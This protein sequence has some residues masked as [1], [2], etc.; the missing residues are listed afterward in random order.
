MCYIAGLQSTCRSSS[1]GLG[2]PFRVAGGGGGVGWGF[3]ERV[4]VEGS[5][6]VPQGFTD[7]R[8]LGF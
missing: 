7:Q 6:R 3:F 2:A 4:F 1:W 5:M 8:V